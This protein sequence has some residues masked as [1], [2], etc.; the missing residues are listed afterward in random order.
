LATPRID[1]KDGVEKINPLWFLIML[2][3]GASGLFVFRKLHIPIL[4]NDFFYMA[5]NDWIFPYTIGVAEGL[6]Q[7]YCFI[8]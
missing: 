5:V 6:S 8:Q 4:D 3:W 1:A 7:K 2:I